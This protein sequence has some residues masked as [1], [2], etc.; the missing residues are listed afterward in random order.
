MKT[1]IIASLLLFAFGLSCIAAENQI[2]VTSNLLELRA[3]L[4][5]ASQ[6]IVQLKK[7]KIAV[8]NSFKALEDWGNQQLNDKL[9]IYEE[10]EK[11]LIVLK[12]FEKR[13]LAE[14]TEHNKTREKYD[15]IKS[16]MGYLAGAFLSLL[17][18][19][20]GSNVLAALISN[21]TPWGFAIN[22][23]GPVAAFFAG[24]AFVQFYF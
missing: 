21:A 22:L 14:K 10:N 23:M 9:S 1:T 8:D 5:Q 17:Y 20:L 24:Y 6:R 13:I 11:L 3:E 7:D 4:L 16:F 15:R 18:L 2:N 19:R 12:D